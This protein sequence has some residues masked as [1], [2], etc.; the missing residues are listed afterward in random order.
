MTTRIP[1]N[2]KRVFYATGTTTRTKPDGD[3]N[4]TATRMPDPDE[5]VTAAVRAL[6]LTRHPAAQLD[7]AGKVATAGFLCSP[8]APGSAKARVSHRTRFP[9]VLT[10]LSSADAAAE[11]HLLVSAYADL[12]R[13]RGW[14]VR[15][16]RG[17]RPRL[18]LSSPACPECSTATGPLTVDGENIW[19]CLDPGCG[20]RTYGSDDLYDEDLPPYTETDADGAVFVYHGTGD[21]DLEATAELAS[22][23]GPDD[24]DDEYNHE[25]AHAECIGPHRSADGY[26]DCDGRAL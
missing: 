19:R 12:L 25:A 6:L 18:L 14:S 3:L 10:G 5:A 1:R 26:A 21:L 15:E 23:D 9:G 13:G 11:E 7:A 4:T 17:D 20:R 8:G 24:E 16:L 22:Q 2:A